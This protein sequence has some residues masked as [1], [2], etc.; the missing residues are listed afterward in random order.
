MFNFIISR[1]GE[2]YRFPSF[3]TVFIFWH[4]KNDQ[5]WLNGELFRFYVFP[6]YIRLWLWNSNTVS[7][8]QNAEKLNSSI[9]N[10]L[11]IRLWLWNSNMMSLLQNTENMFSVFSIFTPRTDWNCKAHLYLFRPTPAFQ[12]LK[13]VCDEF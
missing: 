4:Y 1:G 12:D 11:C 7:F 10:I 2:A 9:F 5:A 6:F 8:L 3:W 13:H